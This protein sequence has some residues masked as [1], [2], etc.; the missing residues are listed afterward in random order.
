LI[1]EAQE[2]LE[3]AP[4]IDSDVATDSAESVV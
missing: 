1:V 4:L 3:E 2:L